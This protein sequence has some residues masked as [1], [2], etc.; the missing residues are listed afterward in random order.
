MEKNA[1][2]FDLVVNNDNLL[3]DAYSSTV[4]GVVRSISQAVVHIS[5]TR[6]VKAKQKCGT[7]GKRSCRIRFY[8]LVRWLHFYK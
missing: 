8:N 2:Q 5:V 4:T 6:K 7:F 3:L 1:L